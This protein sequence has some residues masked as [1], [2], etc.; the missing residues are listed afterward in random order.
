MKAKGAIGHYDTGQLAVLVHDERGGARRKRDRIH[1]FQ[2]GPDE[3]RHDLGHEEGEHTQHGHN[4]RDPAKGDET[5]HPSIHPEHRGAH[6][7]PRRW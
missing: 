4:D 2:G 1:F 3:K 6:F 7:T 5:S